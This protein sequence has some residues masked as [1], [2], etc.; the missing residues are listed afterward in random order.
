MYEN[1]ARRVVEL[2]FGKMGTHLKGWLVRKDRL[3]HWALVRELEVVFNL[4]EAPEELLECGRTRL[5][6]RPLDGMVV[7]MK[8]R[9]MKGRQSRIPGPATSETSR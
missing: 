5:G 2:M 6:R 1:F 9:E 8:G 7:E 4:R 3:D